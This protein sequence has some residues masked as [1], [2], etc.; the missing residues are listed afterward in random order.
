M[1]IAGN[2]TVPW[3]REPWPWLLMAGPAVVVVAGFATL[4]IAVASSDGLVVDDYYKQGMAINQTLQRD[5]LAVQRGYHAT[6]TMAGAG[7]GI[8]VQLETTGSVPLPDMLRLLVVHPTRAGMDGVV[9]LRQ[10][11]PGF[12]DGVVPALADGGRRILVL[13]DTQSEWRMMAD[14]SFPARDRIEF[15]PAT[16]Q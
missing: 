13:E 2:D 1:G 5:T 14:A 7:R 8:S 16:R 4:W 3:Y 12:Y 10:R 9:L 15:K 6:A 11:R